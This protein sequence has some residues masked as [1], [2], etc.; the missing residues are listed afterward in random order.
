M[1][2]I[3]RAPLIEKLFSFLFFEPAH[4]PAPN[5]TEKGP[6]LS[7]P[8]N[9]TLLCLFYSLYL[10]F[11]LSMLYTCPAGDPSRDLVSLANTNR[12]QNRCGL[13]HAK[14]IFSLGT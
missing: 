8:V 4:F 2:V 11:L 5:Y 3:T 7:G 12:L 6:P 9:P 10:S 13:L 14:S 1:W